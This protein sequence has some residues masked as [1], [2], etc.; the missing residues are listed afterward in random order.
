[1]KARHGKTSQSGQD[2][3][4]DAARAR[5]DRAVDQKRPEIRARINEDV[6]GQGRIAWPNAVR[7]NDRLRGSKRIEN[8][9]DD[10]KIDD[11]NDHQTE[12]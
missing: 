3:C 5:D 10:R 6:V 11:K 4:Q 2:D 1:M 9:G 12:K 8:H 7:G